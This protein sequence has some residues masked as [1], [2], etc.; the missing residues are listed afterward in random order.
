MFEERMN[1][2]PD[3]NPLEIIRK[4]GPYFLLAAICVTS[5]GSI[6][7]RTFDRSDE[8][9]NETISGATDSMA[10]GKIVADEVS[11]A[12]AEKVGLDGSATKI[13]DW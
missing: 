5:V 7:Y 12:A 4:Y 8:M 9:V 1:L 2:Q 6:Y 13:R 10:T 3:V 11:G